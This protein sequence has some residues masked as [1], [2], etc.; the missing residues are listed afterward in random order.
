MTTQFRN[1][2]ALVQDVEISKAFY[3]DVIGINI[4]QDS[5]SFVLFEG[6]FAIHDAAL[7]YGYIEKRYEG[8]KMGQDNLDLY[9]TTDDLVAMQ[10]KLKLAGVKFIHGI[11]QFPWGES[12]FRIYDPDSHIIEIGDAK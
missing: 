6:N 2:I 12:V 10:E 3:R 8:E 11:R 7:F 1:S 4:V 5:G 9:M